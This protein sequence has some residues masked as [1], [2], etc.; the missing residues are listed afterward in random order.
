VDECKAEFNEER[1]AHHR[2]CTSCRGGVGLN[3]SHGREI[4]QTYG[5]ANPRQTRRH[6]TDGQRA[7]ARLLSAQWNGDEYFNG[8]EANR[9]MA[10]RKR[11]A[12]HRVRERAD[13]EMLRRVARWK[14]GRATA[15]RSVAVAGHPRAVERT[16]LIPNR[17]VCLYVGCPIVRKRAALAHER[18]AF[19]RPTRRAWRNCP[20]EFFVTEEKR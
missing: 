1:A 5:W 17:V 11:S 7:L 3:S 20:G 10:G 12:L 6:G 14:T 4:P 15:R 16:Q 2:A 13:T 18:H 19:S 8:A 9:Q